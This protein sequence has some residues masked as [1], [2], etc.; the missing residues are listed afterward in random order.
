M[1][2]VVDDT[3]RLRQ[4]LIASHQMKSGLE[5]DK[6]EED[7]I[8][9]AQKLPHYGGH[10]YTATWMLKDNSNKDVWLYISAQGINL[11]DRTKTTSNCGPQL[12]ETFEWRSIQTLCY[13][14]QYLCIIPHTK[15]HSSKLKKYK[16]RMDNK[17]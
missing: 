11:Y 14:K 8:R 1:S 12:Y 9:G 7:F 15:V 16:L 5:V 17:K 2:C 6:A 3:K 10:F 4:E 13:S